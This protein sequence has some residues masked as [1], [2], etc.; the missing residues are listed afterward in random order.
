MAAAL[1]SAPDALALDE[2]VVLI[3]SAFPTEQAKLLASAQPVEEVGVF[4]GRRFF[5]GKI[6]E[7]SVVLGLTGIGMVDA[8]DTTQAVLDDTSLSVT[9]IIFSGVGGKGA[10]VNVG[11]VVIPKEW[12]LGQV[13]YPADPDLLE[14]AEGLQ[15]DLNPCLPVEDTACTGEHID[16][17]PTA[18]CGNA[19]EVRVEDLGYTSDPFGGRAVPCISSAG[20]LLG[21]E[22]CGAPQNES[23]G[24]E[25][26]VADA[27]PFADPFF[28]VGV[29]QSFASPSPEGVAVQDMETGMVASLAFGKG[30]PFLG[31]RA[32]S[33]A[34]IQEG[35]A[36]PVEFLVKAQLAADNAAE[37]VL[38][39]LENL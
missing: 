4:N 1:L 8:H 20:N 31:V 35:G 12:I 10:G 32:I 28:F 18:V 3:L 25:K 6:G 24:V 14:L 38:G 26:F 5:A 33:D 36:Y 21:C 2:P 15:V 29:F 11:D 22:A 16:P 30:I 37:V 39:V 7:K 19:G 34:T 13:T 9:T 27:A 23:P 17:L